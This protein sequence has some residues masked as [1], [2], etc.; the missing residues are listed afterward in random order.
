VIGLYNG[1]FQGS[2]DSWNWATKDII[3][4]VGVIVRVG[5]GGAMIGCLSWHCCRSCGVTGVPWNSWL[6]GIVS[7]NIK[8]RHWD[9][10]RIA[11]LG[12]AV[13]DCLLSKQS[14]IGILHS[15]HGISDICWSRH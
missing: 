5:G 10:V 15:I 14:A 4:M 8:Y 9:F 2:S 11:I 1:L 13:W 6:V 3:A 12:L 7:E